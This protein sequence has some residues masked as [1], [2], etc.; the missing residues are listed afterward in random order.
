MKK[1]LVVGVILLFLG[2]SIPAIATSNYSSF[3]IVPQTNTN[4]ITT[5]QT[6][7]I[8]F[9]TNG[10]YWNN[11]KL[12][13]YDEILFLYHRYKTRVTARLDYNSCACLEI[14]LDGVLQANLSGADLAFYHGNVTWSAYWVSDPVY[15]S[16]VAYWMD[17]TNSTCGVTL[18]SFH[19]FK[20]KMT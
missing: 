4:S 7:S 15:L 3:S 1:L 10:I 18:Y 11:R 17:G 19:L 14:F 16:F 12:A 13:P 5:N 8:V 9:P 20:K 2:S 6:L